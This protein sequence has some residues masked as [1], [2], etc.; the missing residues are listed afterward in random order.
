MVD[1]PDPLHVA[2]LTK[3]YGS[4]TG[5]Q[6]ISFD[7]RQGEVTGLLGPN[8]S[9]KSTTIH[10][11]TG[12]I[13]PTEGQILIGGAKHST[14]PAKDFFGFFPD[15]LPI[16]E[17]LT[18]AETV[19]FYRRLRPVFDDFLAQRLLEL[20]GLEGHMDKY[21]GAY[22]HGMKRKLQLVLALAHHP[23]L[24]VLDEPM[25]GLDP[26]AGMLM[27][28]ILKTF[29]QDGGAALVATHDLLAAQ[30]Y[31]DS[32]VILAGGAVVSS[33]APVRLMSQSGTS[34]LEELFIRA[35]GLEATM[36]GKEDEL[37]SLLVSL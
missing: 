6:N 17:S 22:S 35:T 13:E 30:H 27:N 34:S 14:L 32:V 37:R 29:V 8:G 16:P 9:G 19:G 1:L 3:M 36:K 12:F 4:R 23:R 25:R 20:L 11:I 33:G 7:V 21:V 28:V 10:C 24:L 15:D 5:V 2:G 18:G 26:E 31:C